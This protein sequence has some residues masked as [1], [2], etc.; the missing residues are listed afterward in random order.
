MKIRADEV[1]SVLYGPCGE[2][3]RVA[4]DPSRETVVEKTTVLVSLPRTLRELYRGKNLAPEKP[5][6]TPGSPRPQ[7]ATTELIRAKTRTRKLDRRARALTQVKR[8]EAYSLI[9]EERER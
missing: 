7:E 9:L 3:G 1:I 2:V 4:L 6:S 5:R 8:I